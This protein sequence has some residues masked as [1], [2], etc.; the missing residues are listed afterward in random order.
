MAV[1]AGMAVGMGNVDGVA[2]TVVA[3]REARHIT[4]GYRPH[5][6]PLLVVGLNVDAAMKVPR[7]RLAEVAGKENVVVD[8]GMVVTLNI[9]H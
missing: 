7:A 3:Y 2:K 6:P 4:V 9:E 8:G 5:I 1:D